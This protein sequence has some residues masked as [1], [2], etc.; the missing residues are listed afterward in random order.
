MKIAALY[1]IHGNFPALKA[2]LDEL[3]TIQPDLIIIGG[4]IVLGPMPVQTLDCLLSLCKRTK[5]TFIISGEKTPTSSATV[6]G[7]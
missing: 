2:V 1:D 4:D 3:E 5:V 7:G 6:G